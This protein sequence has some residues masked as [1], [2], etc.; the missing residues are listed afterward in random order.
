MRFLLKV[1][2]T[3]TRDAQTGL[4]VILDDIQYLFNCPDGF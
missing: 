4:L 1:V 3:N 2:S